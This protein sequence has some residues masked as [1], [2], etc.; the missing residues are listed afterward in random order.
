MFSAIKL[1][2]SYHSFYAEKHRLA[3]RFP[4]LEL[5]YLVT[6]LVPYDTMF[7]HEF[8]Y[9]DGILIMNQLFTP[10]DRGY[11]KTPIVQNRKSKH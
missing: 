11:V 5:V 6:A 4:Y 1:T 3:E 10:L 8:V 2:K 9:F 7:F